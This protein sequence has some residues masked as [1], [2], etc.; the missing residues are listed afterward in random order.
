MPPTAPRRRPRQTISA[1]PSATEPQ[2]NAN[3]LPAAGTTLPINAFNYAAAAI[4]A[5]VAP[6]TLP[7]PRPTPASRPCRPRR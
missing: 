5:A 6:A 4:A 1:V 3:A 7:A 2:V